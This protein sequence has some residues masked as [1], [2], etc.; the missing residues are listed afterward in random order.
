MYLLKLELV[1]FRNLRHFSIEPHHH[2]NLITGPN[3]QGKTNILESIYFVLNGRSF[4]TSKESEMVN[5]ESS[6]AALSCVVET[7]QGNFDIEVELGAGLKKTRVNGTYSRGYPLGRPGAV[8]FSPD[9]LSLVKGSPQERRNFLDHELCPFQPQYAHNLQ[10]YTRALVQRN[11]LL[12]E[13][14]EK[15]QS[16]ENLLPWNEQVC[17][18]GSRILKDRLLLLKKFAPVA[19]RLHKDLSREREALDIHYISSVNIPEGAPPDEIRLSF[20]NDLAGL[21]EEEITRASTLIGPHRDDII[22]KINS[23]NGRT[24]GSQGQQRTTVLAIKTA[25]LEL[26]QRETGEFPLLL[27]D[28]VFFELDRERRQALLNR[29]DRRVQ[30]FI[31]STGESLLTGDFN[32]DSKM[33]KIYNGT[34]K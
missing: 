21:E 29:V 2:L 13:V 7:N 34:I 20:K 22:F 26:W 31:T 27:L 8:A 14:R 17:L 12:R 25:L 4:R 10:R 33:L 30:T 3:A 1:D 6:C 19:S 5:R 23:F 16:R 24:F 11:N 28:D 15:R 18:Y 32:L 9:D